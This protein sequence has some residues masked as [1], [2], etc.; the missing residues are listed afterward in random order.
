MRKFKTSDISKCLIHTS[1]YSDDLLINSTVIFYAYKGSINTYLLAFFLLL[2]L[3]H[4]LFF[5]FC[6]VYDLQRHLPRSN[7][8]FNVL[9][10][11]DNWG[12]PVTRAWD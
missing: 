6:G 3:L 5:F 12:L 7:E 11:P 8:D 9:F 2:L 4:F 10:S 1:K